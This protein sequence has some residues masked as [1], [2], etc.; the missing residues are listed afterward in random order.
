M[1]KTIIDFEFIGGHKNKS[2][3]EV[4]ELYKELSTK[5]FTQ[6]TFKGTSNL[7]WSH[8]YYD[9]ALWEEMLQEHVGDRELIKT[10]RDEN[11]PK[12]CFV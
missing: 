8:A 10:A 1:C 11:T 2:L 12:V 6:S 9:T 4:S 7:V 3:D 5:I